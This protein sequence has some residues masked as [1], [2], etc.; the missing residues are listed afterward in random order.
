MITLQPIGVV[1]CGRIDIVDDFWGGV[2]AVIELA[3]ELPEDSL[4]G[5]DE[6]SHAEI[7]YV[8]NRVLETMIVAG[9]RHPRNNSSWPRVGIFAQRAKGRPNR[10]GATIVRIMGR[11][12]RRLIVEG[13]D[14]LDGTPVV[15]IKPVLAEFLPCEPLR[16]PEWS[17]ALMKDYWQPEAERTVPSGVQGKEGDK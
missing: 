16:Q 4:D 8:F 14:A 13:L 12:G 3:S 2:P 17:R 1:R 5:L 11:D 6:F 7:I 15:D 9:A 10:L